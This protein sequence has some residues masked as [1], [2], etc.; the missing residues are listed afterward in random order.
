MKIKILQILLIIINFTIIGC[1]KN[2]STEEFTYDPMPTEKAV[3]KQNINLEIQILKPDGSPLKNTTITLATSTFSDQGVTNSEGKVNLISQRL[4]GEALIFTFNGDN[5][6]A[7]E[8]FSQLPTT[9]R[10]AEIFFDM[11]NEYQVR[12]S[13]YS[14]DG[15]HR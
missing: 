3:K 13:H 7:K 15:L 6:S 4:H 11:I 14:V 10:H 8:K 12:I 9:I 1:S 2:N 5:I